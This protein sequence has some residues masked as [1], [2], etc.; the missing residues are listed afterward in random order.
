MTPDKVEQNLGTLL[1]EKEKI[2]ESLQRLRY[3][4]IEDIPQEKIIPHETPSWDKYKCRTN[5]FN[6]VSLKILQLQQTNLI[7]SPETKQECENFLKFCKTI[8]GTSKFYQQEDIDR[9]NRMLDCLINEL[10]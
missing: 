6:A 4:Y 8:E 3:E 1:F 10:S 7:S 2:L 5:F 9:A